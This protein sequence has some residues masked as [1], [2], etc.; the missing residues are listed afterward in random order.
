MSTQDNFSTIN[1]R[2]IYRLVESLTTGKFT[3]GTQL[4][5][6]MTREIVDHDEFHIIGGRLWELIP[7]KNCYVL[8]YQYGNVKKI[9]TNYSIN[10]NEQPQFAELAKAH[11]SL[12]YET[13]ELLQSKGI[14]L[15]S[16]AGVGDIVKVKG[17]KYYQ[18]LLGFNADEILQSFYETLTIISSVASISIRNLIAEAAKTQI[19]KDLFKASEIQRNLLPE[20]RMKFHDYNIYGVCLP[21]HSVGGDYFDYIKNNSDEEE[22]VGIVISDAASKGV[23]AAIQSLFVSGA[24]RMGAGYSTKISR[25]ISRLNTLIW[26]TFLY[27]RFVTLFYCELTLSSNRLVLYA[28]AGHCPP[29]HY[30]PDFDKV[31]F[32]AP[33]GGILGLL[34]H[35]KFQVE[36]IRMRV[37]DVLVLYTDGITEAQDKNGNRYG[38]D[39]LIEMIKQY[40]QETPEHMAMLIIED[41]QKFTIDSQYTDD[42]TLVVIKREKE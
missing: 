21:D 30:Q 20:H 19:E 32:L 41:I 31:T 7:E 35:Q 27:E 11:T 9:P 8:R 13:D 10:L 42:K 38:D 2:D 23:P 6:K 16:A 26:E 40:S 22:R 37:G 5:K 15:Y 18:Y 39:R 29:I 24:L 4:L 3:N 36:N 1:Q 25:L 14:E 33:T 12:Y 28:N 17:E 34:H